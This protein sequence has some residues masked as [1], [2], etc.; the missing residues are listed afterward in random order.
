MR[1]HNNAAAFL[2]ISAILAIL[3]VSRIS[4]ADTDKAAY[5]GAQDYYEKFLKSPEKQKYRENWVAC[6]LRFQ[7]AYR[8]NP[9]G[10][11]AAANLYMAGKIYQDLYTLSR[12]SSDRKES[13]DIFNRLINRHP[14]SK[15]RARAQ[16]ALAEFDSATASPRS[17][18]ADPPGES[19]ARN[20][21][22]DATAPPGDSGQAMPGYAADEKT[23]TARNS[24]RLQ[25]NG[26]SGGESSFVK[27]RDRFFKQAK[28]AYKS[29][30][31]APKA[32]EQGEDPISRLIVIEETCDPAAFS[33]AERTSKPPRD[34]S[35]T[36][37]TGLRFWSNPNYTRIVIDGSKETVFTHKLLDPD[38]PTSRPQRLYIDFKKSRLGRGFEKVIPIDDDLLQ[39]AR[40]GQCTPDDV[41]VV[42]DIKS[43]KTYK[44][45]SLKNPFRTIIDVWGKEQEDQAPAVA[46][47][48]KKRAAPHPQPHKKPSVT[49]KSYDTGKAVR[50]KQKVTPHDLAKQFA[51]G[52]RRIVIDAGH[53]GHDGGAPGYL[54]GVREKDV[55]LGIARRLSKKI[56][57]ELGCEVI[58]TRDS[59]RFLTLE[60]RTAIANTK[61]ADLFISIHCNA[62]KNNGLY[63]IETYYLNLATD[64]DA[65]LVAARENATSRKSISDLQSILNDLMQNSKI[66]ESSR[67]AGSVQN[68][69][70][71]HMKRKYSHI[72]NKGVKQAPFY[73][74]LG[75]QM[76]S[77]LVETS[78]ISNKRECERLTSADYQEDLCQAI[79]KGIRGYMEET[80]PTA[81]LS[82]QPGN[83]G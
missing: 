44:I 25:G 10:D 15:Y 18:G 70:Y 68:S 81:F 5:Y 72:S 32:P 55:V 77:I 17:R 56:R 19:G 45:F 76:P 12:K 80:N 1:T 50:G 3:S 35:P 69:L 74:L 75:A 22:Q 36:K 6:I 30:P 24:R 23:K 39:S 38:L 21:K 34:G 83:A 66:N 67:L 79:V 11:Y 46:H 9:T 27:E 26:G 7:A 33:K 78:F 52:V 37:I 28:T 71:R 31:Q 54:R 58:M 63:G 8:S 16:A 48:A 29:T 59:D 20:Q 47:A 57:R 43:F 51:L 42:V 41:R 13:A 64:N 2:L 4:W 60:E 40:A 73:V 65:I 14:K 61:N 62:S 53:G 49:P 82:A